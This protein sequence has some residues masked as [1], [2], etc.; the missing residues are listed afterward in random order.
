MATPTAKLPITADDIWANKATG[1]NKVKPG[2]GLLE[3]GYSAGQKPD[4]AHFNWI[5]NTIMANL[6]HIMQNGLPLWDDKTEYQKDALTLQG[7]IIYKALKDNTGM[8]T[9]P[10]GA[11]DANWQKS[12]GDFADYDQLANGDA[13]VSVDPKVL[14]EAGITFAKN[15]SGVYEIHIAKTAN[16]V[17]D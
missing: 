16:I 12:L 9:K 14:T 11:T 2:V 8:G 17:I 4:H 13:S 15:A 7:G 6:V 10:S 5:Y 1:L 3:P